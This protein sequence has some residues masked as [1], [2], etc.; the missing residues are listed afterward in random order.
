MQ[1]EKRPR[2]GESNTAQRQELVR[3]LVGQAEQRGSLLVTPETPKLATDYFRHWCKQALYPAITVELQGAR[4][5]VIADTGPVG[6]GLEAQGKL[7]RRDPWPTLAATPDLQAQLT[8]LAEHYLSRSPYQAMY[9]RTG[10][11]ETI[12][13]NILAED[14]E[15]AVHDLLTLWSHAMAQYK[16]L[17]ETRHRADISETHSSELAEPAWRVA[18]KQAEEQAETTLD[19]YFIDTLNITESLS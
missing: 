14:A 12:L 6:K 15:Q 13:K 2:Q 5:T 10:R 3:Y 4:A 7:W 1:K 17:L 8:R 11:D 19:L 18:L 9:F 16:V